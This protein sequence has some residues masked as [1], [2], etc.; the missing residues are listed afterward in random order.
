MKKLQEIIKQ[1]PVFLNDWSHK[2][3]VIGDFEGIY[4]DYKEYKADNSPYANTKYWLEKKQD[5]DIAIEKYKDIDI[6]FASYGCATY[7]R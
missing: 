4:T 5:M 1:E 6:L 2:I 3:D 7:S